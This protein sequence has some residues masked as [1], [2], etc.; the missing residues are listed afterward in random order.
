M[1]ALL[2]VL[3]VL[4]A[5][6]AAPSSQADEG[7]ERL[8]RWIEGYR[9]NGPDVDLETLVVAEE[10]TATLRAARRVGDGD[11]AVERALLDLAGVRTS[12]ELRAARRPGSG[13]GEVARRT[14]RV[15]ALGS[16]PLAAFLAR[17]ELEPPAERE[18][19]RWLAAGVLARPAQPLER[20]L[21]AARLLAGRHLAGTELGLFGCALEAS[22]EL[23]REALEALV[24]WPA[25][26]VH[27]FLLERLEAFDALETWPDWIGRSLFLRHFEAVRVEAGGRS[28]ARLLER[29][30]RR[31]LGGDWRAAYRAIRLSRG[32]AD[33][34]AVPALIAALATWVDRRE[35]EGERL[36]GPRGSLRIE[37]E[38]LRELGRR[39]GRSLGPNPERWRTWWKAVGTGASP[40][41][42]SSEPPGLT[43]A[44]FFGLRPAT[45][46]V[47]FVL[48][49]SGSMRTDFGARSRFGEAA[50]QMLGF[51]RT[52]GPRARFNVVLFS[53]ELDVWRDRLQPATED[54]LAS[55]E[56]W[57]RY[58]RPRGA[59]KLEPAVRSVFEL[60]SAG[61]AD[62]ARLEA[63]S[64]VVLCDGETDEGPGWI[65]P[66]LEAV[67]DDACL[68]FHGVRVGSVGDGSLELLAQRTGGDFVEVK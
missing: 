13:A 1:H 2:H 60:D 57:L 25:E 41:G 5:G 18:L 50:V 22:P 36:G 7:A 19:A 15:R 17:E 40:T 46:R 43:R 3:A 62:L 27:A 12:E 58:V 52:L 56:R 55:L 28:E 51:L 6:P 20:R 59:T 32:L 44:E 54:N 66:L 9:R 4:A 38:L 10:L 39:S 64:V 63:D 67:N 24:G 45:D 21:A 35:L 31:A 11:F 42:A 29:V 49:R 23:R 30:G 37:Y 65:R 48:D 34:A 16:A 33:E 68:A 53:S 26:G 61:R 14:E 47:V 8:E